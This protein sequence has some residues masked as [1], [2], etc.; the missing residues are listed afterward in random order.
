[1][2]LYLLVVL[3]VYFLNSIQGQSPNFQW[4]KSL[5]GA[6]WETARFVNIDPAG[7]IYTTGYF[8]SISDF[9]PGIGTFSLT[10]NGSSDIFISKLDPFGNFIWAKSIGD[11]LGDSG[12]DID[13]DSSGNVY[14]TG[15][16]D[17][18]VDFDPGPG[19]F[20]LSGTGVDVFILKLDPL[21]NF[22][23]AKSFSGSMSEIAYSI[24]LD[25][26]GNIFI[27]G[28]FNG[29]VDFDPG[30][31]TYNL[32]AAG[33]PYDAFV[34]KLDAFGNF[35]W[36]KQISGTAMEHVYS[37]SIQ[38][39]NNIYIT[40]YFTGTVDF[41]PGPGIFNLLSNGNEDFYILKLDGLGNFVWANA[42]GGIGTDVS[43]EVASDALNN[44]FL[45][46]IFDGTVDFDPGLSVNNVS[47]IGST[48][49]FVLK[50]NSAGNF[51]W[52]KNI[53]GVGGCTTRGLC[54]ATDLSGNIYTGG[55]FNGTVD[56]DPGVTSYTI[57]SD[58]SSLDAFLCKLDQSG[59]F[60]WAGSITGSSYEV[61]F[62]IQIDG[63]NNIYCEGYFNGTADF[64]PGLGI[65]NMTTMGS[66]D[67]YVEKFSQVPTNIFGIVSEKNIRVFPNPNSGIFN[68]S[69]DF[70]EKNIRYEI[71]NSYGQKILE[72][73]VDNDE[74][75]LDLSSKLTS[76][77]YFISI[78]SDSGIFRQK[79]IIVN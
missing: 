20:N 13:F 74:N 15:N 9:D 60:I 53:G 26:A 51:V 70:Y 23:W 18:T 65:S 46:G 30:F 73:N 11:I 2:R 24:K 77:S 54:L 37:T 33:G 64:D 47:T 12:C 43:V 36:A 5:G 27:G 78:L 21:G 7:N 57:S 59:N 14:V 22:I 16:F 31:G 50:L 52:V 68:L 71:F 8:N 76:G 44:V 49:A 79:L 19:V 17:G 28:D 10:S 39:L 45:A 40:G 34:A 63:S 29:T 35:T 61:V 42:I 48:D 58:A 1:M 56:F 4:A 67:V 3:F 55:N 75:K 38:G 62:G 6:A 69:S 41:D 72:G 66:Y 25:V 32:T